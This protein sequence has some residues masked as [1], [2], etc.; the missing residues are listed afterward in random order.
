L[1][2]LCANM[3]LNVTFGA[4]TKASSQESLSGWQQVFFVLS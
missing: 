2:T 4:I 3:F 1:A